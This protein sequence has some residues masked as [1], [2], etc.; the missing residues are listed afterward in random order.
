MYKI[1]YKAGMIISQLNYRLIPLYRRRLLLSLLLML[2]LFFAYVLY[3]G[4]A[5]PE[6]KGEGKLDFILPPNPSM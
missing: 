1:A 3:K 4:I 5:V 2:S 6:E